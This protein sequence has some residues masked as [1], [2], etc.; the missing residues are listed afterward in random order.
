[1]KKKIT[2]EVPPYLDTV[3]RLRLLYNPLHI[4]NDNHRW[5]SDRHRLDKLL[6]VRIRLHLKEMNMNS[7]VNS[8]VIGE[9]LMSQLISPLLILIQT[10][11][12][13]N[14]PNDSGPF[15]TEG[16]KY[17]VYLM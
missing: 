7:W 4:Y 9:H 11:K 2:I 16:P 3:C 17:K 13:T 12:Q 10:D 5:S 1:M 8:W 14:P 15:S 6:P